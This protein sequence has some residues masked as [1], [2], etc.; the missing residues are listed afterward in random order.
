MRIII[1]TILLFGSI[2]SI[3]QQ[4]ISSAG[5]TKTVKISGGEFTVSWTIG[6]GVVTTLSQPSLELTQGFHQPIMVE[7]FPNALED[8][9]V[10][11]MVAYPNPTY[12]KVLFKGGDPTGTYHLRLVDKLGR[13]LEQKSVQ[14]SELEIEM[15][16]YTNGSYL[17]EVVEDRSERRVIF[18]I[19]KSSQ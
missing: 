4:V 13:V 18:N 16:K 3:S 11:D 8:E 2:P 14:L 5:K 17:I 15:G 6:E 12:D 1:L 10:L 7:I 19:I 9:A